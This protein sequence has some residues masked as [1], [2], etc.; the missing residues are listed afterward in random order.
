[1]CDYWNNTDFS[2]PPAVSVPMTSMASDWQKLSSFNYDGVPALGY[3]KVFSMR[4][5]MADKHFTAGKYKL[6][7][8][9]QLS[10]GYFRILFDG[11][12]VKEAKDK[13]FVRVS[14]TDLPLLEVA[15]GEHTVVFEFVQRNPG[16]AIALLSWAR[17]QVA[18]F[19]LLTPAQQAACIATPEC[20]GS[21]EKCKD[22]RTEGLGS[23]EIEW[24]LC[25][26][27]VGP[28]PCLVYSFGIR[29]LKSN[30][31]SMGRAGCEVHAFDCTVSIV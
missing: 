22:R 28:E 2:G 27:F 5:T 8:F 26:D 29:D 11:K 21:Q 31:E 30:E 24:G 4:C 10:N 1:M 6:N 7:S 3:M 18:D 13:G 19:S 9:I 23:S 12:E 25:N 15:E 17:V 16:R 20:F 14:A